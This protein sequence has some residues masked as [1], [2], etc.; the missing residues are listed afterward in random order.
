MSQKNIRKGFDKALVNMPGGLGKPNTGFEGVTFDP[1]G[2]QPYQKVRL[3]PAQVVNPT[4]GDGYHR[5]EGVY[6]IVLAYPAG[7]GIGEIADQAELIKSYFNRGKTIVEGDTEINVS[8]TPS[9]SS[10]IINGSRIEIAIRIRYYSN[11]FAS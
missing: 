5:E 4:L 2:S 8:R 10:A 11:E 1:V 9:I 3:I 7:R 6:Q